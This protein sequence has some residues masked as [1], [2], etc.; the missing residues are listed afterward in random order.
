MNNNDMSSIDLI[1]YIKDV[2]YTKFN[3]NEAILLT[4]LLI[5]IN[6]YP[7]I[8]WNQ[9]IIIDDKLNYQWKYDEKQQSFKNLETSE[10]L[11]ETFTDM[12]LVNLMIKKV[13]KIN[14]SKEC[15][16]ARNKVLHKI[17]QIYM[18]LEMTIDN[19][20]GC[21]D[22]LDEAFEE[23]NIYR[24][25]IKLLGGDAQKD[26]KRILDEWYDRRKKEEAEKENKKK[27]ES[28]KG[29]VNLLTSNN[30]KDKLLFDIINTLNAHSKFIEEN[31]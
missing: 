12:E 18:N 23:L 27:F 4:D 21:M 9:Y 14:E 28:V 11:S 30:E 6:N 22:N 13:S 29:R 5:M 31:F 17:E 3:N 16:E 7:D 2:N 15:L 8:K 25:L 19:C 20:Q 26:Y 1:I 10:Y 24:Q